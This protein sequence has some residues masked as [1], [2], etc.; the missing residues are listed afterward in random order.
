M[1]TSI[2][3][4]D[5]LSSHVSQPPRSFSTEPADV[6]SIILAA[7]PSGVSIR[8]ALE[9]VFQHII[10]TLLLGRMHYEGN[11]P[12]FS[13]PEA[14]RNVLS[15]LQTNDYYRNLRAS[16]LLTLRSLL[17]NTNSGTGGHSDGP[18]CAMTSSKIADRLHQPTEGTLLQSYFVP[19]SQG[20]SFAT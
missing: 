5:V 14:S 15:R 16:Q 17:L 18:Y 9:A 20:E 1:V 13:S 4:G 7:L 8:M 6:R 3:T 11:L 10:E 12:Y 19:K 2:I